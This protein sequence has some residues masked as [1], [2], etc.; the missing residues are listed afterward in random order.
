MPCHE[1]LAFA[2]M[3]W[4]TWYNTDCMLMWGDDK[5]ELSDY[6][7]ILAIFA[8][9]MVGLLTFVIGLL[10][11]RQ[12]RKSW[13]VNVASVRR[14]ERI[15]KLIFFYSKLVASAHPD[16]V[17]GYSRKTDHTFVERIYEN[18]SN[19]NMLFDHR[20]DKDTQAANALKKL[21]QNAIDYYENLT[22]TPEQTAS[23][24][25]AYYDDMLTIDKILSIFIGVEWSRV[26]NEALTGLPVPADKCEAQYDDDTRYYEWWTNKHK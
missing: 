14:K 7:P 9:L 6:T 2:A 12:S 8:T 20:F 26:K 10:N 15:D 25:E 22:P 18:Y 3:Q 23:Y 19:L 5:M 21:T 17:R 13:H 16:V 11:F 1:I 4:K 24:I